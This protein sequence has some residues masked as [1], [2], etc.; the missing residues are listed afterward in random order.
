MEMLILLGF[1]ML[2]YALIARQHA[3]MRRLMKARVKAD[4]RRDR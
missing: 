1:C 4:D 3:A 2:T